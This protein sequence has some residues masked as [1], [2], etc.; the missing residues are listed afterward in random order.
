[1][2]NISHPSLYPSPPDYF[3]AWIASKTEHDRG[4]TGFVVCD[5]LVF[6]YHPWGG[7]PAVAAPWQ[8]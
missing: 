1:M 2:K 4:A 6:S 3:P 8:G 5:F 7:P